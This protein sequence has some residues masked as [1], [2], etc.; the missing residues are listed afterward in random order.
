[1][2]ESAPMVTAEALLSEAG[3]VARRLEGFEVRP[4][5]MAMAAAVRECMAKRGR[6]LVEAGTGVGKSFAYLIPAIERIVR[7][8]ERVVVV[9]HTINLQEQL[10]EKDIPLLN[11]VI[12]EEFS[13]VLVKGRGNY[14]SL[15]R[16]QLASKRADRLFPD[17]EERHALQQI[18]QWAYETRDGSLSTLPELARPSVWEL[19]QSDAHNCMGRRCPTYEKCFYQ[20]ARRR[21]EHGD[22]LVCNH[23]LFFSDLAMRSRGASFLPAYDHVII[24]EAHD[25]E[26]VASEHFG[27]RVSEAGVEHL[28]RTLHH[29]GQ[30]RGVLV[31]LKANP[32]ADSIIAEALTRVSDAAEASRAF[33]DGVAVDIGDSDGATRLRSTLEEGAPA[34]EALGRLAASLRL[35]KGHLIDEEDQFELNAYAVRATELASSIEILASQSLPGCV[36]WAE[37]SASARRRGTRRGSMSLRCAAID[38]APILAEHLFGRDISVVLTSATLTTGHSDFSHAV[39]R[40]GCTDAE[41]LELGSPFDFARQVRLHVDSSMPSPDAPGFVDALVPRVRRHLQATDGGAFVLFTSFTMLESVARRLEDELVSN[42]HS[43]LVQGRGVPRG[44][45]LRRFRESERGVLFG[46]ASFWQGIDVRGRALRNVIICK[47]PFD[48]PD[49]PLVEARRELIEARGGQPFM[50]DQLPRAVLRF[51][52]GFGRLIRSSTDTGRVVVLDPRIVTKRYGRAF[53]SALPEGVTPIDDGI[54]LT[55]EEGA[56]GGDPW[57]SESA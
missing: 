44:L 8:G 57:A 35:L 5:Q 29:S 12:P 46:T 45:L 30:Q 33:F 22:L 56:T 37:R 9:T 1:M 7:S 20:A 14:L 27:L 13:A 53:L 10:I 39:A 4:Q 34:A 47:L 18:E 24:D 42:G 48:P 54:D 26:M 15:R 31:T 11:A 25:A 16:L 6:L 3:A 49:Q 21:M 23:A 40:F 43:V 38:A 28:L 2:A 50:D 32:G 36:Y 41:T 19:A 52:Q 51:R 17:E 55:W